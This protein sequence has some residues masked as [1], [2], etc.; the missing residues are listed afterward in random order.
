M[1]SGRSRGH[2]ALGSAWLPFHVGAAA[3]AFGAL[4]LSGSGG[5]AWLLQD[6]TSD[7]SD[8]PTRRAAEW[9]Q[10]RAISAGFPLLTLSMIFGMIWAQAA[11]GRY[12]DWNLKEVW[13]LITWM[14]HALYWHLRRR[15][16][17]AGAR[18][19]WLAVAGLICALFTFLA[20]DWLARIVGLGNLGPCSM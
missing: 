17:W 6:R 9:L 16:A 15:P 5:I 10:F 7:A 19:A 1:R 13:T 12:W 4:A 18:L 2:A 3:A 14:V 11:W 20:V 8:E